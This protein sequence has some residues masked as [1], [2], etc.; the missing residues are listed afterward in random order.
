MQ[1][2]ELEI[3]DDEYYKSKSFIMDGM[4]KFQVFGKKFKINCK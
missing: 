1:E 3:M 4:I 2:N